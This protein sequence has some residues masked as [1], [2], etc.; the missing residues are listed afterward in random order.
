MK[1]PLTLGKL[2]YIIG[3]PGIRFMLWRSTRAYVV[4]RYKGSILVTLNWLGLHNKWRLPGGGVKQGEDPKMGALRELF[5]ETGI[6]VTKSK[7]KQLG[8]KEG[9]IAYSGCRYYLFLL[10]LSK[11]PQLKLDERELVAAEF[12][13]VSELRRSEIAEELKEAMAAL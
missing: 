3:Y 4:V 13:S 8:K 12:I 2:T 10:D 5:E 7:L 9:Y 6:K 1:L 11:E